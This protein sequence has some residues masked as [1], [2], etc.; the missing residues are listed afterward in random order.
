MSIDCYKI[1]IKNRKFLDLRGCKFDNHVMKQDGVKSVLLTQELSNRLFFRLYQCANM[2]HKT[3]TKA[4]ETHKVTTQQWAIFGAL[5]DT[6]A[7]DGIPVGILAT[8]LMVSRQNLLGVLSRME[9]QGYL[10]RAIDAKDSRSRRISLTDL[11]RKTW[12]AMQKDIASYYATALRDFSN[13]DLIH[14]LHYMD[15]M[16]D[17]FRAVDALQGDSNHAGTDDK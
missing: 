3:G 1:E 9:A 14:A 8:H 11:G 2:M 17:N 15:K 10:A 5:S 13:S 4:L 12:V 7:E 16:R 6:R